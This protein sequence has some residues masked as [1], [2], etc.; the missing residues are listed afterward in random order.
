[1]YLATS[2]RRQD[3]TVTM[4]T[5]VLMDKMMFDL[6]SLLRDGDEDRMAPDSLAMHLSQHVFPCVRE[7]VKYHFSPYTQHNSCPAGY[8][9]RV[10]KKLRDVHAVVEKS[11]SRDAE[12][13]EA[14]ETS[15]K[16]VSMEPYRSSQKLVWFG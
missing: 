14:F 15:A 8:L 6:D 9:R 4:P 7:Y 11:R 10:L 3:D 13:K 12:N 1:M 16:R 2:P 5:T